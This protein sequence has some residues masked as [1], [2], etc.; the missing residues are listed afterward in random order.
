MM[1][2][3]RRPEFDVCALLPRYAACNAAGSSPIEGNQKIKI[4][5]TRFLL[6]SGLSSS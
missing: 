1:M 2:Y 3:V 6:R 5:E 4:I